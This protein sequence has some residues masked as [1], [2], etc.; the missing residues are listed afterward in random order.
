MLATREVDLGDGAPAR[1]AKRLHGLRGRPRSPPG[2]SRPTAPRG[3][4][5]SAARPA[6]RRSAPR[7]TGRRPAAGSRRRRGTAARRRSSSS[8][9]DVVALHRRAAEGRLQPGEPAIGRRVADRADPVGAHRPADQ[10]GGDGGARARSTSR[11]G[12]DRCPRGCGPGRRR[13]CGRCCRPRTRACSPPRRS[14]PRRREARGRARTHLA[15]AAG[16]TY[17]RGPEALRP[18]RQRPL[19][20]DRHRHPVQ[21]TARAPRR[22]SVA[23]AP[24][25]SRR[26]R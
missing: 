21:R 6:R 17:S 15:S 3:R 24:G 7:R 22:A 4:S 23:T 11:R 5:R 10:P 2:R 12:S 18:P 19:V 20:L 13:R 9:G 25:R 1:L 16:P 26:S 14:P 8:G